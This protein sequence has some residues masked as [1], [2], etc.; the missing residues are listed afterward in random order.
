MGH[1]CYTYARSQGAR[2]NEDFRRQKLFDEL[3]K[4]I[5]PNRE[6]YESQQEKVIAKVNQ[7]KFMQNVEESL[8]QQVLNRARNSGTAAVGAGAGAGAGVG[9]GGGRRPQDGKS[10]SRNFAD[11]RHLIY[12]NFD[13]YAA[14]LD[15]H[16]PAD[17]LDDSDGGGGDDLVD[18][19]PI[20]PG[21]E[22]ELIIKPLHQHLRM[23]SDN[24]IE[25][26]C[27]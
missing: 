11:K 25:W 2:N 10:F 22:L 12:K 16:R 27:F 6:E 17:G 21:M 26:Q 8:R 18:G 1:D 15:G 24:T 4:R 20:S 3:I 9:G 7:N 23:V 5:Y 13:D 19:S 14:P